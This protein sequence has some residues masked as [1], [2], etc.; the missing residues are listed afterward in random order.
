MRLIKKIRVTIRGNKFLRF[1]TNKFVI[2]AAIFL[3]KILIWDSN[4]FVDWLR[5]MKIV[6]EQEEQ[7]IYYQEAIKQT[8]ERLNELSSNRDSLEKF[9]REQYL[10]HEPDEQ[11]FVIKD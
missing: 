2:V 11:V 6:R 1:M 7:K 10:F 4:N 8:N 3:F 5:S 9:A